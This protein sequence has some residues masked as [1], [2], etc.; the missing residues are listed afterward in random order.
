MLKKSH[1]KNLTSCRPAVIK[2][3]SGS[4]AGS[5]NDWLHRNFTTTWTF[6]W[7]WKWGQRSAAASFTTNAHCKH[8]NNVLEIEINNNKYNR[9]WFVWAHTD[10]DTKRGTMMF[11]SYISTIYPWLLVVFQSLS[12]IYHISPIYS[13]LFATYQWFILDFSLYFKHFSWFCHISTIYPWP[14]ATFKC[15]SKTSSYISTITLSDVSTVFIYSTIYPL[16]Y[17]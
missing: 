16:G 13:W 7:L 3:L 15:F 2:M 1:W 8:E 12:M 5:K 4:A 11:S 17:F 6:H 14:L 10:S 9:V